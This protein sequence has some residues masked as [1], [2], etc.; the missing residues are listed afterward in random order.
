M[1]WKFNPTLFSKS[2][3][4]PY[5]VEIMLADGIYVPMEGYNIVHNKTFVTW[6]VFQGA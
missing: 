3:F 1:M 5:N 6:D 4:A 2:Q